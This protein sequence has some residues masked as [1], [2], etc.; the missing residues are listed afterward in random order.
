MQQSKK[1]KFRTYTYIISLFQA[2]L[3]IECL[4]VLDIPRTVYRRL[5]SKGDMLCWVLFAVAKHQ[6]SSNKLTH[7]NYVA[8]QPLSHIQSLGLII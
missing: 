2:T 6:Y 4:Y 8:L 5:K 1:F 3:P 7:S